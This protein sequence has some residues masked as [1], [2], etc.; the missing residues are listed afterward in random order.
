MIESLKNNLIKDVM[1]L[2]ARKHR[3]RNSQFVIEGFHLIEE[4]AQAGL[5]EL[6]I[7]KKGIDYDFKDVFVV[8]DKVFNHIKTTESSQGII[9]VCKKPEFT[10]YKEQTVLLVDR[11]QDPGN[12]GTIIRSA[13]AFNVDLIVLGEGTV[14]LYNPK[15]IN[16]SQG[17]LFHLP[18]I[19]AN[20]SDYLD[21]FKGSIYGTSLQSSTPLSEIEFKNDLCFIIGNEGSGVSKELLARTT[22]NIIIEMPGKS[23]SLNV[24]VATSII[25]YQIAKARK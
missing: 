14:D 18:I 25:L 11:V 23:E 22:S 3:D 21:Q 15:T 5:L 17:S 7:V 6:V 19:N 10:D 2:Q 4:A 20:L 12:L 8:S 9:G 24:G 13:D 16:S 1:K